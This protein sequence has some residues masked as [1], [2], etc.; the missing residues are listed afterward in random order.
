MKRTFITL[1]LVGMISGISAQTQVIAHRGFWKA[2]NASQNS[3]RALIQADSIGCYGSEL[4]VWITKDN[5]LIVNHDPYYR[6]FAMETST[7]ATLKGLKL[8]NGENMPS[9][10]QYLEA[11]K[12]LKTKLII[13]LKKHKKPKRETKAVE[14]IIKAVNKAGLNDRVEYLT[15]SLHALKEFIRV[16]P[17]GTPVYYLN[18]DL[19]PKELKDLGC[20]GPD[21]N[22]SAYRKNPE[23]IKEAQDLGMKVNVW[24]VNRE[25][26]MQW[27]LE[28]KVDFITTDMPLMLQRKM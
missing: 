16:A 27:F 12:P 9:L 10:D 5:G 11:A 20:A 18:G 3:I 4:D 25:E 26:D 24:T 7:L 17:A 14:E 6:G 23:W 15:F 21:Y 28:Q 13:E 2:K 22:Q 8:S 1:I 19:T